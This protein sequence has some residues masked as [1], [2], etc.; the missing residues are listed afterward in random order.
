MNIHRIIGGTIN[1][2]SYISSRLAARLAVLIFSVPRKAKLN[3]EAIQYLKTA[4]QQDLIY[5]NFSFKT[6]H[7][8]GDKDTILLVHGWDSNSFRWK[9][10]IEL[11]KQARYNIIS[12]DAPAHG[13]SGSKMFN[14]PLYS[15]C[16]NLAIQQ[17]KPY[18]VIGHSIGGTSCAIALKN[19]N[20][21]SLE[22]LVLLGAPSNLGISV[23]NYVK[24]MGYNN[25]VSKAIRAH[26]LKHF[27]QVPEYYCAENFY[28]DI[29]PRGLIVHDKKDRIIS[30][31]E[32]LDIHRV[33]KNSELIKTIGHGHRLKSDKVY[34][35]ILNFLN[36]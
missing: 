6:Y 4:N 23:N 1:L 12:I 5:N 26:Y 24:M 3:A 7:W 16:I 35:Y 13:A 8:K 28:N 17:F 21:S 36:T 32:A 22:K 15:E 27:N 33:Y 34:Q 30:F 2:I 29:Q 10:L 14:A 25:R 19:H 11:L 20:I 18:A 31:K 9:D